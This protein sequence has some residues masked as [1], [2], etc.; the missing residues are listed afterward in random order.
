MRQNTV[1]YP[2]TEEFEFPQLPTK[3]QIDAIKAILG[4]R[5]PT[6]VGNPY[7]SRGDR[8]GNGG[9]T[10]LDEIVDLINRPDYH[11][12][13]LGHVDTMSQV[14][15]NDRDNTNRSV[16]VWRVVCMSLLG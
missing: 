14:Q 10:G 5:I 7:S 15:L 3:C 1:G 13:G 8:T 2:A 9:L 16:R 12:D 6:C 4:A 11:S